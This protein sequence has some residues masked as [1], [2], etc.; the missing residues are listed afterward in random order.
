MVHERD[1]SKD[2]RYNHLKSE[3]SPYLIQHVE[4]PVTGIWAR[5]LSKSQERKQANLPIHWI[6]HLS[7]VSCDGRESF[8]DEEMAQ[9]INEVF[10][11]VK[12]S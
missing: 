2:K 6:F 4:N 9:L 3:K 1:N 12:G 11:P 10:V 7:L 8:E 5:K